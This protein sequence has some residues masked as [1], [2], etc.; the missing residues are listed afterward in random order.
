ME[1]LRRPLL[2]DAALTT[3]VETTE[4]ENAPKQPHSL[5]SVTDSSSPNHTSSSRSG[6][7]KLGRQRS[8]WGGRESKHNH[9]KPKRTT[10]PGH[11][12]GV[13]V[14]YPQAL[15]TYN[16]HEEGYGLNRASHPRRSSEVSSTPSTRTSSFSESRVFSDEGG[17]VIDSVL[18]MEGGHDFVDIRIDPTLGGEDGVSTTQELIRCKKTVLVFYLNFLKVIGWRRWRGARQDLAAPC[19]TKVLN[20]VYPSFIFFL[21]V[22]ASATQLLTCF[23]RDEVEYRLETD[24]GIVIIDCR[25]HIITRSLVGDV[26][27]LVTYCCGVYIFRYG[28]PEHLSAL[29]ERVYLSFN[30][31]H[32]V[33][34]QTR[35]TFTLRMILSLAAVWML[36]SLAAN[37]LRLISLRLLDDNTYLFFITSA[38][39]SALTNTTEHQLRE[40]I[41]RYSFVIYSVFGFVL[42]DLLYVAV[43]LTYVSHAQLLLTYIHSVIDKVQTKAYD[44]GKAVRDMRQIYEYLKV[45]N[46]KVAT[47]TSLCLF[48]FISS[49]ISSFISLAF[50]TSDGTS[51]R[52]IEII[53]GVLNFLQWTLLSLAPVIQAARLT[54]YCHKL[55]RLGLEIGARP[56]SYHDTPQL[57]LDSFLQYTNATRYNAKL[58]GIPIYPTSIIGFFFL[59]GILATWAIPTLDLFSF[60]PWL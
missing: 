35:L 5:P 8:T 33:K 30:F 45:L 32:R 4:D 39:L 9:K 20:I 21:M 31:K 1:H 24:S 2:N 59:F 25:E 12:L 19:Y 18:S 6:G 53:V 47:I 56:F 60:A 13:D 10:D 34:P 23:Y 17:G 7:G 49:S 48:I 55:R 36:L 44:L 42:F 28:E 51:R 14:D 27:L 58:L 26:L 40:E 57:V 41:L 11:K 15:R 3:I 29:M 22:L 54:L 16:I 52:H 38:N 43:V 50:A 46:G 37:I